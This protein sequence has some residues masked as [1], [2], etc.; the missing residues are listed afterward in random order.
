MRLMA[1]AVIALGAVSSVQAEDYLKSYSVTGRPEVHV[2]VD[3]SSVR[4]ITTDTQSVEFN[5]KRDGHAAGLMLGGGLKID[6]HQD[7]NRVELTVV[8]KPGIA[9]GYSERNLVTEVRM[10][11]E[12]DLKIES[13]DGAIT[14]DAL[15]GDLRAH[16]TDGAVTV[17]HFDGQCD[18]S[19]T[20]GS[21][22]AEGRFD[23][24]NLETTDGK[25]LA[26]VADGSKMNSAWNIRSVDGSL[27]VLL[28][29][30][31]QANI[32][33]STVDGHIKLDLP[34]TVQGEIGKSKVRGTM[35][36]GGQELT[37]KSTDGSIRLG[38]S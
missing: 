32:R 37:L 38:E 12:G 24:L 26:R 36:G 19:S 5:V 22:R 14:V 29:R 31:F 7:G 35:N 1:A 11:R 30:D 10:P 18:V 13:V 16:S 33:A 6:S 34:V 15:K 9:L 8:H 20:D 17:T 28:P 2:H 4:V 25:V 23:A 3:D 27:E 21:L